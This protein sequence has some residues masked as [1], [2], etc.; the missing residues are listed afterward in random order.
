LTFTTN[1][2]GKLASI[3]QTFA[4][5]SVLRIGENP[6]NPFQWLNLE[7]WLGAVLNLNSCCLK[8]TTIDFL[9]R[10]VPAALFSAGAALCLR[11]RP[12]VTF[13]GA[14]AAGVSFSASRQKPAPQTSRPAFPKSKCVLHRSATPPGRARSPSPPFPSPPKSHLFRRNLGL[15]PIFNKICHNQDKTTV[16]SPCRRSGQ[17][18]KALLSPRRGSGK[19]KRLSFRA[20]AVATGQ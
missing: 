13:R 9:D 16:F 10:S 15:E 18:I 2:K 7:V 20:D 14:R 6:R 1:P 11:L 4:P 3:S 17:S 5:A 19:P 8:W 12:R